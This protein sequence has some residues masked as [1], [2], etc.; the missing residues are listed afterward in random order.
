MIYLEVNNEVI[1]LDEGF[2]IIFGGLF[3]VNVWMLFGFF[4]GVFWGFR[5]FCDDDGNIVFDE[6]GFLV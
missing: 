6:N 2:F 4:I 5:I 1:C 3:V